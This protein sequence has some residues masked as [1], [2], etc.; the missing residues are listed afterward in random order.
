MNIA[1]NALPLQVGDNVLLVEGTHP[2]NAYA[3]LNRKRKGV[4][5]RFAPMAGETAPA[6]M[7]EPHIDSRARAIS[8]SHITF[9]RAIVSISRRLA[10][11][12]CTR[13][14]IW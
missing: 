3:F 8:L 7:F 9:T 5:A 12:A 11:S 2:N 13:E 10:R 14:F 4:E 6:E 1:A